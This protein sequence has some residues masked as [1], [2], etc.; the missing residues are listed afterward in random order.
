MAIMCKLQPD[1]Q[2]E[3]AAVSVISLSEKCYDDGNSSSFQLEIRLE[4][5]HN[6][7]EAMA[8]KMQ[9]LPTHLKE[10]FIGNILRTYVQGWTE[11]LVRGCE[12]FHRSFLKRQMGDG[13]SPLA[14]LEREIS[15]PCKPFSPSLY[16]ADGVDGQPEMERS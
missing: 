12:I 13:F 10:H 4:L 9:T 15:K 3:G 7:H 11:R 5:A 1:F 2:L 6:C 16:R 14:A 8:K